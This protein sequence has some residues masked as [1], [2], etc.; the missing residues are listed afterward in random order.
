MNKI[1]V[2]C[3]KER[4]SITIDPQLKELTDILGINRSKIAEIAYKVEIRK[5]LKL[6][7]FNKLSID[8]NLQEY[9]QEQDRIDQDIEL[10]REKVDQLQYKADQ[11]AQTRLTERDQLM[12]E[13]GTFCQAHGIQQSV[14]RDSLLGDNPTNLEREFEQELIARGY[15]K[16]S[17]NIVREVLSIGKAKVGV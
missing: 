9:L 15:G 5:I 8:T 3:M 7:K 4:T 13:F 17:L 14:F 6:S 16:G 1:H 10:A 2:D 12:R 11:I